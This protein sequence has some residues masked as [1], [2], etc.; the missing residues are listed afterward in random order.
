MTAFTGDLLL[1]FAATLAA[2]EHECA[3]AFAAR[4]Q[5]FCLDKIVLMPYGAVISG[6]LQGISPKQELLVCIAGPLVNAATAL[7]FVALWWLYPE[8]YPYTE[9]AAYVSASLFLVN[10]LPAWPLDGGRVLRLALRPIGEKKAR[11]ICRVVSLCIAAAVLG[12]FI[13][14]C[15]RKP[16]FSALVFAVLLAAGSFGG[17]SYSRF[18]PREKN[19]TRGLEERRVAL[20]ADCTAGEAVRLLREDKYLVLVLYENGEFCGELGEAELLRELEAGNYSRPL[21]EALGI[22]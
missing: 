21:R 11:I 8:T 10:L 16:V 12:Y 14:S 7:A 19:F 3:H 18:L 22:S 1:F 17:G 6:D 9:A 4:R 20:S 13:W 5:G 2:L 15:F